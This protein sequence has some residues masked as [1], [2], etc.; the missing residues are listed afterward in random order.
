MYDT[1][2]DYDIDSD[3]KRFNPVGVAQYQDSAYN[4]SRNTADIVKAMRMLNIGADEVR[5]EV[6]ML[7]L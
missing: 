1:I 2:G 4:V 3:G 7:M 5:G 6:F